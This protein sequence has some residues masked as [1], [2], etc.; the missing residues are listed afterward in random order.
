MSDQAVS[1]SL[2]VSIITPTYNHEAYIGA[3]LESVL[4]QVYPHWELVCVNDASPGVHVRRV[5]DEYAA[6]DPRVRAI[7]L[8]RNRGVSGASSADE[9]QELATIGASAL[10][11]ATNGHAKFFS[12]DELRRKLET[13]GL[14][15]TQ[16]HFGWTGGGGIE[17]GLTPSWSAKAEYLWLDLGERT[18][19]LSRTN[20]GI[21]ASVLRF[22]ANYRF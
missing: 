17:V 14:S 11:G 8:T 5:L 4:A 22:G 3:C 21:E 15:E 6:A 9:D 7:H 2:L 20:S 18:Y 16:T 19:N 10:A 12:G 1:D 13:G